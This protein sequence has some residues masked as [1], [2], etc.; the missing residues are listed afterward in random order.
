M[1]CGGE[2]MC[3]IGT[4]DKSRTVAGFEILLASL[5][6][7][8]GLR[9]ER[10]RV[11]VVYITAQNL[12]KSVSSDVCSAINRLNDAAEGIAY[13]HP[14]TLMGL[15][16]GILDDPDHNGYKTIEEEMLIVAKI[17][18]TFAVVAVEI[19]FLTRNI[20]MCM[21]ICGKRLH[22]PQVKTVQNEQC[23]S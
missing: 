1:A 15:K 18:C 4:G 6:L 13:T 21:K 3:R 5:A 14:E 22:L 23:F 7:L 2:S 10:R 9:W 16:A 17:F 20:S 8:V 12:A 19:W 11:I